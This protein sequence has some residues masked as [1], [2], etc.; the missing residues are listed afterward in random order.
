VNTGVQ[1][2]WPT[3]NYLLARVPE[4]ERDAM[5]AMLEP[6]VLERGQVLYEPG[7]PQTYVYLP[8]SGMVTLVAVMG[9]GRGVE[10]ATVGREG[11]VG[12]SASGYVDPSF[13][14]AV[15]QVEGEAHRAAAADFEQMIDDSVAFCS[16]VVRWREL[17]TRTALQAVACNAVH[18][19]RQ[20]AARWMLTTDDRTGA[21]R[22][23]LTQEVLADMLGV[24]RNAVNAV[25]RQFQREGL[26]DYGRGR[27]SVTDRARLEAEACECYRLIRGEIGRLMTDPPSSECDD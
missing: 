13:M 20:R 11:A 5:L 23:P 26:I 8:T 9:D 6:V 27:V 25:A 4:H 18:N 22:L 12:M 1:E 3:G 15:V 21:S 17:L 24:K 14:R 2:G 19:V 10:T 16:A 7:D